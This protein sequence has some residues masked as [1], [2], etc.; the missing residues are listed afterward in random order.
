MTK[1]NQT[2]YFQISWIFSTEDNAAQ[3]WNMG[4]RGAQPRE[5]V[6]FKIK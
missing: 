2:F 3:S 1:A 5:T 6:T 4:D